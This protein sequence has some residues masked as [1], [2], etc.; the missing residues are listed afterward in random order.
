MLHGGLLHTL[1]VP[2][3]PM[4]AHPTSCTFASTLHAGERV[5]L[6][7][8][9]GLLHALHVHATGRFYGSVLLNASIGILKV[10]GPVWAVVQ[11]NDTSHLAQTGADADGFGG[12]EAG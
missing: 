6:V 11:W 8:H 1:H 10:D 7:L 4:L 3:P 5:L 9:G 2:F 12:G